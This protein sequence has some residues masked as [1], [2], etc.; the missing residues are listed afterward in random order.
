[1]DMMRRTRATGKPTPGSRATSRTS[2]GKGAKRLEDESAWRD[3]AA[4]KWSSTKKEVKKRSDATKYTK[5]YP[6]AGK[7][8]RIL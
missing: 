1:M 4:G 3:K 6:C 2:V 8:T 7:N 5:V